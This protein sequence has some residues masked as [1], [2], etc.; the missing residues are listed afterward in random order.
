VLR[1][2]LAWFRGDARK[3]QLQALFKS[4]VAL[5]TMCVEAVERAEVIN[6]DPTRQWVRQVAYHLL[7]MEGQLQAMMGDSPL[8]GLQAHPD[9]AALRHAVAHQDQRDIQ[10]N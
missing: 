2:L 6:T 5:R 8:A 7:C 3:L 10:R 1:R 4:T 9:E